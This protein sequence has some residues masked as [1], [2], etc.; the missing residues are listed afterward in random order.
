MSSFR[1]YETSE[2][3]NKILE[4]VKNS[5]LKGDENISYLNNSL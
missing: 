1:P 3:F 5:K 4:S 2:N